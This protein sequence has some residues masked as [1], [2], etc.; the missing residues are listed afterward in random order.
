MNK[1]KILIGRYLDSMLFNYQETIYYYFGQEE[2]FYGIIE[3][4]QWPLEGVV[5]KRIDITIRYIKNSH[6]KVRTT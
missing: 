1:L 2:Q 5:K 4:E 6:P 3:R